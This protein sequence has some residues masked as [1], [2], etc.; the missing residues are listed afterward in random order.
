MLERYADLLTGYCVDVTPGDLVGIYLP[1]PALPLARALTRAVLARGGRPILRVTYPEWSEDWVALAH[2]AVL[3][4][5]PLVE[6]DE[7][8]R[9]NK[10]IRVG[11]PHN[12]RALQHADKGK[13]LRLTKAA[14]GVNELRLARTRWVGT[15][16][17][18]ESAAQDAGMSLSDFEAFVFGAMFLSDPDPVARWGAL[19]TFQARLIERL[20]VADEIRIRAAG[21]DLRL[22]VKGRTWANSDGKRNM[23][24]GEVFT[25]PL[26]NSAEGT[27]TFDLPSSVS[28]TVVRGARLRFE[29]GK[30]VEARADEGD[31][32]L[33]AQLNTDAGARFLGEIGIG[34]NFAITKPILNTLYDEKIGG[35]VHLA[36]GRSYPETGGTNV[37]AIHWD[38]ITDLRRGGELL[39]DGEVVQRDGAFV[40]GLMG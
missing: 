20:A 40:P 12:S 35:T 9:V 37:S 14:Q 38:L 26:E 2:D 3:D 21:T 30:V 16:Y 28:G 19:R 1:S 33:Q 10:V 31:D 18:T 15:L 17:P 22:R 8:Q 4:A 27:I 24:S 11:A 7:V 23:P 6:L 32:L 36:L 5:E 39:V 29:Q 34:T 13:L 25:G